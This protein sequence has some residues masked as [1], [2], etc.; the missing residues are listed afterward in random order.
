VRVADAASFAW[1]GPWIARGRADGVEGMRSLIMFGSTPSAV[2]WDPSG[3]AKQPGWAIE[4]GYVV[5]A[6]DVALA[7]PDPPAAPTGAGVVE[8]IW[9]APSAGRPAV[10]SASAEALPGEGLAGDRHAVGKGTFASGLPGSALTLIDGD[11]CDSFTP[12]LHPDEHRRNVV[13]RGI[14]LNRLVGH[15]FAIGDV[16]C[17]GM[18][19]CEPCAVAEGYGTRPILRALV[20]RGGLRADILSAG[21]IAVGDPVRAISA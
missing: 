13:T 10:E 14:D 12:P 18:R 4:E 16:V 19:L 2:A 21:V 3:V 15:E 6:L 7:Q 17:R 11:V 20:H 5:A 9:L 1:S 8:S